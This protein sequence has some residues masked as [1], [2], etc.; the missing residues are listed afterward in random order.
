MGASGNS[1]L[2]FAGSSLTSAAGS[3]AG[4]YAQSKALE[5]QGAY[6]KQQYDFNSK[7]AALQAEDRKKAGDI[8]AAKAIKMGRR[9]IGAQKAAIAAGNVSVDTGSAV[10]LYVETK[11]LSE[12]DAIVIRNNAMQEAWGF[13]AQASQYAYSGRFAQASSNFAATNTLLAGGMN[14][15]AYTGR[16]AGYVG[17]HYA[18]KGEAPKINTSGGSPVYGEGV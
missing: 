15:L 18:S 5:A 1:N 16:A 6:E 14:A 7:I 10:D 9:T 2:Y 12:M 4:S 3:I 13:K 11:K 8:A 17:S